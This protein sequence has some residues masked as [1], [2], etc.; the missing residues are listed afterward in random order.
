[1]FIVHNDIDELPVVKEKIEAFFPGVKVEIVHG[2]MKS[3]QIERIMHD[4]FE[5]KVQVLVA[6]SI[7]ESGLDVPSANTLIVIGAERFGLSQLYQLKGR[8][9][10]GVEKGYC[11]LLTTPGVKLTPEAAKRL[12]A[13]KKLSP[14]GGGFQLALKDLEIR[15][16]GTLLGPKQ[17]GFVESVGLDLYMKLFEEAVKEK[18]ERDVKLNLP[19]EAF[20]PDDFI[21][22]PREKV[23]LY[24]Q[25]ASTDDPRELMEKLKDIRGY[26]PDP[27][28]NMFKVMQLKKLAREVGVTE[29]SVSS[30][31]RAVISFGEETS[32]SPEKLVEFVKERKAVFTPERKLFV[33][34]KDLDTL[35]SMLEEL[36]GNS[37]EIS[38]AGIDGVSGDSSR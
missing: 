7:V 4:F 15:G 24:S 19:Y 22:D 25:I 13:M 5:G 34:A 26:L 27:I 11:Y 37:G 1:M 28:V 30:S 8:V 36:K 2:Q 32:V 10:R 20:I 29:I 35:I 38:N 9:G 18:E 21:E 31:G 23:K 14:L 33:D 17:S 16:A 12:E 6:T 3:S